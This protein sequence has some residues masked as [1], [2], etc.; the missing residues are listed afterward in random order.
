MDDQLMPCEWDCNPPGKIWVRT[1]NRELQDV[2]AYLARSASLKD[3]EFPIVSPVHVRIEPGE[4]TILDL[5][6]IIEL[7]TKDKATV[8]S[9]KRDSYGPPDQSSGRKD[10]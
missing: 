4:R 8:H 1:N 7:P 2:Y 6:T 9:M 10:Q 5:R 3:M